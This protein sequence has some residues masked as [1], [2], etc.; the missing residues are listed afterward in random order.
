MEV[1]I[2]I[3]YQD[4]KDKS[5][6]DYISEVLKENQDITSYITFELL[7]VM[8]LKIMKRLWSLLKS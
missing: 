4:I 7:K 3:S 2:N 1:S 8:K 6:M 5:S